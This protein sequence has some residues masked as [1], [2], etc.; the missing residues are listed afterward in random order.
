MGFDIRV[1]TAP[2]EVPLP[3][4]HVMRLA[5]Y[6]KEDGH[7]VTVGPA[8]Q[9]SGDIGIL[10]VDRTRVP[11]EAVPENPS[12]IPLLN[13][14][15]LDISKRVVSRNLVLPGDG[16]RGPV[17]IK[18]N[19]N[20]FGALEI[21]ARNRR[22]SRL[23]RRLEDALPW[24]FTRK[25]PRASYPVLESPEHVPSWVWTDAVYVVERFLPEIIDGHYV[26]RMW[27]FFGREE[28]ALLLYGREPVVKASTI[29]K[30]EDLPTVPDSLRAERERLGFDFGKFDY[31]EHG[32][33]AILLDA[34]KTPTVLK[35]RSDNLRKLADGL[36][37]FLG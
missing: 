15:V 12:G 34:N 17:I 30:K 6:W 32:G 5:E 23:R 13:G 10:H 29:V 19:A 7:H 35:Q 21:E 25:L 9:T 33:E 2:G 14:R 37:G 27:I 24:R 22:R 3:H 1:I 36:S 11:E 4:H 26:L 31:V 16:Y 8:R 18:T 20:Y 28:Y